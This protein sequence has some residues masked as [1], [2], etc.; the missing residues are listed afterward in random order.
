MAQVF[1]PPEPALRTRRIGEMVALAG[2]GDEQREPKIAAKG[3][4]LCGVGMA[5]F[6]IRC[7]SSKIGVQ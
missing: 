3:Q 2:I 1:V 6:A 7:K 5:E 4:L